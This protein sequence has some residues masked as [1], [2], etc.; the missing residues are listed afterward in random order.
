[1]NRAFILGI[2]LLVCAGCDESTTGSG[3]TPSGG[4]ASGGMP[5]TTAGT[6][7]TTAARPPQQVHRDRLAHPYDGR[8]TG[9]DG[10]YTR[11]SRR[12]PQPAEHP[13]RVE[14]QPVEPSSRRNA[15]SGWCPI[16]RGSQQRVVSHQPPEPAAGGDPA[17]GG[18]SIRWR[19]SGGRCGGDP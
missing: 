1:M 5:A 12:N 3:S 10:R 8:H 19:P 7:T 13:Q 4:A 16:S 2:S 17:V 6:P 15:S 9:Y 14:C 11:H 18:A